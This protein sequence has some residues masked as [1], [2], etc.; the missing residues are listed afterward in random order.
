MAIKL[1]HM[2]FV[3]WN[4][5]PFTPEFRNSGELRLVIKAIAWGGRAGCLP[6]LIPGKGLGRS[7]WYIPLTHKRFLIRSTL[8]SPPSYTQLP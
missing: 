2:I 6:N 3:T 4:K 1:I 7:V 8:E 5:K